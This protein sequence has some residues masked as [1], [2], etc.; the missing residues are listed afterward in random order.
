MIKQPSGFSASPR[1]GHEAYMAGNAR[2]QHLNR[3]AEKVTLNEF[4]LKL[5]LHTPFS[6]IK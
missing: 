6:Y 3:C 5:R 1:C 4:F 2:S